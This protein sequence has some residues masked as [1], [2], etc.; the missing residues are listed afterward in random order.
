[1]GE[2]CFI[3]HNVT[4][5]NDLFKNGGPDPEPAH[6][7]RIRLGDKVTVGSGSTILTTSICSGAVIG[8][9]SVV[10]KPI[11]EKGVYLG[12]PARWVRSL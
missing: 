10:V 6:W 5:A 2:D 3:G 7:I 12:N 11:T 8:A 9:G 1:M 4:F